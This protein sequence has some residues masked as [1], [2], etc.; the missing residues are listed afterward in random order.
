VDLKALA[1]RKGLTLKKDQHGVITARYPSF[2]W[3]LG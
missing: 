3:K 1:A 2:Q